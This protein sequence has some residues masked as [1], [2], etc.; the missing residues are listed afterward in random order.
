M[1]SSKD[2]APDFYFYEP[3]I[4]KQGQAFLEPEEVIYA[5]LCYKEGKGKD[6][7]QQAKELAE[8]FLKQLPE[9]DRSYNFD[10]CDIDEEELDIRVPAD[11]LFAYMRMQQMLSPEM[12]EYL[13]K[14]ARMAGSCIISVTKDCES[15]K[16]ILKDFI[17]NPAPLAMQELVPLGL[18]G[19]DRYNHP[20]YEWRNFFLD[21]IIGLCVK[22]GKQIYFYDYNLRGVIEDDYVHRFLALHCYVYSFPDS[23]FTAYLLN[24]SKAQNHEEF[25]SAMMD[26]ASYIHPFLIDGDCTS[27][28]DSVHRRFAYPNLEPY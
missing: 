18:S 5:L 2:D 13:L 9:T 3:P 11:Q 7:K 4:I 24:A 6:T 17:K 15:Q 12:H 10:M 23:S 25:L 27:T 8:D 19:E 28:V 22:L 26:P 16:I 1:L 20:Y 14:A 21:R